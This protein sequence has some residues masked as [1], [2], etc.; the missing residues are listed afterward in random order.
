LA[1]TTLDVT[2]LTDRL[3]AL[4][5][6]AGAPPAT[7]SPGSR[8]TPTDDARAARE[9][10]AAF[11]A[12]A[13][14]GPGGTAPPSPTPSP[15][16]RAGLERLAAIRTRGPA[17]QPV[18]TTDAGLAGTLGG[19]LVADGLVLV[20]KRVPLPARHGR[21]TV[22]AAAG[23]PLAAL[24]LEPTGLLFL[25]TETTGLAGGTGTTAFLVGAARV[26]QGALVVRQYLLTRFGGEPAL[27]Q[28]LRA[29]G[30]GTETL[31]TFNGKCFDLPLLS[32]R[33]R[34]AGLADPFLGR[35]HVD[36]LH[37]VR[38]AFASR[39]PDCRLATV[40]DRLLGF[41][42]S[43]DLPGAEVPEAW[44]RWLRHGD[45]ARLPAVLEHNHWDLVSLAALVSA[46]AGA[47]REPHEHG[48]DIL[49]V[50]RHLRRRE[51]L[52]AAHRLL[53]AHRAALGA[54]ALLELARLAHRAGDR[55]SAV[56]IWRALARRDDLRALDAL[57]KH[58]EHVQGDL[59]AA[60]Q[61]TERL[62]ALQPGN[63]DHRRRAARI[64]KKKVSRGPARPARGPKGGGP[65]HD[66][67]PR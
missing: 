33:Y 52:E 23:E 10:P 2:A 41:T 57:A 16:T 61:L 66:G 56:E 62:I 32:A 14:L 5:R 13:D 45:A 44:A 59:E 55:A 21:W 15:W 48:A 29:L 27:L 22:G 47:Y 19:T 31:V 1:G 46:L 43:G 20:E 9:P 36:L 49:A 54:E 58:A 8:A 40:E 35:A 51:G 30:E 65:P 6:Q 7:A 26:E 38:R 37:P 3:S 18:R 42:R 60:R 12:P 24:G 17:R 50:A 25:D 64:E 53:A 28:S 63:A 39:W 11:A 4:R 34:L 67:N